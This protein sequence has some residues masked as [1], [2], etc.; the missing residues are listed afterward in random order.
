MMRVTSQLFS[1]QC[2]LTNG[3]LNGRFIFIPDPSDGRHGAVDLQPR[4]TLLLEIFP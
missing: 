4:A 2:S 1:A 3:R